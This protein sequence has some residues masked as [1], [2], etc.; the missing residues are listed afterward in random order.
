MLRTPGGVHV[1]QV[2][3][4]LGVDVDPALHPEP[5]AGRRGEGGVGADPDDDQ[6]QVGLPAERF[7]VRPGAVHL[8][9]VVVVAADAGDGGAGDDVYVVGGQLFVDQSSELGV[10]GGQ[11][12]RQRL[13]L[14]D[15]DAASGE[16]LGHLQ[17]DVAGA[18][19]GGGAGSPALEAGRHL[20]GVG[21]GVQ[22]VHPA[23]RPHG[24]GP[25]GPAIGGRAL[26]APV[27]T[28]RAS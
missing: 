26:T 14:G 4:H 10:D 16:G 1:G 13:D 8:E 11:H 23:H 18:D 21:H 15:G 2:G 7:T 17:P 22:Q 5:G 3:A 27:P 24:V 12:L 28:T 6:D 19:H 25:D 20:E 9:P